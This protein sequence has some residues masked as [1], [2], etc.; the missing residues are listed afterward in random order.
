MTYQQ[1]AIH[2]Q[3]LRYTVFSLTVFLLLPL[4]FRSLSL[5][6]QLSL[7][8]TMF[9]TLP[10]T[11]I[12]SSRH[13]RVVGNFGLC[14]TKRRGQELIEFCQQNQL[15]VSNSFSKSQKGGD[16]HGTNQTEEDIQNSLCSC[17]TEIQAPNKIQLQLP[18][19]G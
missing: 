6:L 9:T 15:V 12:T 11:V 3:C 14:E 4:L 5:L 8:T 1:S 10:F 16:T 7:N 2:G 18:M 13:S 19:P 17:K